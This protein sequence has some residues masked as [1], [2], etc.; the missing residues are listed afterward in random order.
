MLYQY[1]NERI[2][3]GVGW[4]AVN[5]RRHETMKAVI[6]NSADKFIDDGTVI[7][8][9]QVNPV[10]IGGLLGMTRTV[11]K[12]AQPGNPD[13][14]W[15]DSEAWD[16][17]NE[18]VGSRVPLDIEMGAGHLN[19]SRARTQFA[20]GEYDADGADIPTL[21][22]DYGTTTGAADINRYQ[23]AGELEGGSFISITLAWDRVVSFATD[24]APMG[25]YNA[26]DT[27]AEYV[28]DGI[29]PPDDSVIN[30]LD[31]F[32]LPKFAANISQSIALSDSAVGTVEHLFFQIPTTGEY[33]FWVRQHDTDVG[34]NQNYAVAWW[35]KGALPNLP[36]GDYN[37]DTIVD[38][39]DYN[40][41]R[42]DFGESIA[43]GTGADGNGNGVIDAADYVVWRKNL[44]AAGS[45][46]S[47][48]SVPEPT[49]FLLL[50]AALGVG[51]LVQRSRRV[52]A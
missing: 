31:I 23:F 50:A 33:E 45:G 51:G 17:S 40:V 42:G 14:T 20:A 38:A 52:A 4:N 43:A 12:E 49:S 6:L 35:T 48:A 9:G 16:D 3:A 34:T 27:F 36:P 13:P 24:T 29:S 21:G 25:Q 7:P 2:S 41:W 19:A 22:W 15:F 18:G 8:P 44:S 30:D 26:G 39:E 46:S 37:G 10:P 28:D 47:L 1:A 5:S 32:L 11:L